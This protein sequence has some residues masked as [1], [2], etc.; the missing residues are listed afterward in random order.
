MTAHQIPFSSRF[1]LCFLMMAFSENCRDGVQVG[2]PADKRKQQITKKL[3]DFKRE[4]C[5]LRVLFILS[6]FSY[7][8]FIFNL[9]DM[10]IIII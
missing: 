8:P 7:F 4:I 5:T 6:L 2:E 9:A 10:F 1:V 3:L